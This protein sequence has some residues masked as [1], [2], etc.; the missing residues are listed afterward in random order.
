MDP[1]RLPPLPGPSAIP[2]R[3]PPGLDLAGPTPASAHPIARSAAIDS[4][5]GRPPP[6]RKE[7][8]ASPRPHRPGRRPARPRRWR[9]ARQFLVGTHNVLEIGLESLFESTMDCRRVVAVPEP[10]RWQF[11]ATPR[12]PDRTLRAACRHEEHGEECGSTSVDADTLPLRSV[13]K[14]VDLSTSG[15]ARRRQSPRAVTDGGQRPVRERT[16]IRWPQD[17]APLPDRLP[18]PR[19]RQAQARVCAG[20]SRPPFPIAPAA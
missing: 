11:V 15:A 18:A 17:A 5:G 9:R 4:P 2:R 13:S 16:G 19:L 7:G 3:P 1:C 10:R 8:R 6:A 12:S 20:A 14:T